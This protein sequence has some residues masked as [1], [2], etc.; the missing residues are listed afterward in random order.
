MTRRRKS[1]DARAFDLDA[2]RID[3][4]RFVTDVLHDPETGEPF[5]LLP[6][7]KLFLSHAFKTD[8]K[9]RLVYPEL[10][11]SAPKKSG[12]TGFAA[13]F[14]LTMCLLFGG[15]F[16]EGY[17]VANDLGTSSRPCVPGGETY[18]RILA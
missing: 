17:C 4:A 6:A 3:P 11:F 7:E 2:Y 13:L 1:K 9:G 10:L 18:R 16:A 14:T 8:A 5:E 12:K 15:K